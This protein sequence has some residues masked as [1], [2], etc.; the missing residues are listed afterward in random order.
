MKMEKNAIFSICLGACSFLAPFFALAA[1][2]E[3]VPEGGFS[4]VVIPD[5]Q[6]YVRSRPELYTMQTGWVA[7]NVKSQRL[8]MLLH[9]GDITQHN[10]I[11]QWDISRRAHKVYEGLLPAVYAGGN[12]DYGEGG[13]TQSRETWFSAYVTLED[14]QKQPGFGGVYER[15]PTHTDNSWHVL[16]AGGRKWLILALEFAAR[17]EV[18]KWADDVVARHPD[19]SAILVTHAFLWP[20]GVWWDRRIPTPGKK[21]PNRGFDRYPL[22]KVPT[23]GGFNDAG[24]LWEK[25]VSRH[26]NFAMVICGHICFSAYR[27]DKGV[28]GNTVHQILVDY[29]DLPNGGD[30]WLRLLQFQPDGKTVKVRDYSPLFDKTSEDKT[31][32]FEFTLDPPPGK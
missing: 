31:C 21:Q 5:P 22:S 27:A 4:M 14:Y 32:T 23:N 11:A 17:D 24:D 13:K 12:H 1:P 20:D 29:Q 15:E 6:K 28:H 25:L 3:P 9:V 7:A 19:H 2:P 26:K 16:E 10:T 30:T 18:I 8:A